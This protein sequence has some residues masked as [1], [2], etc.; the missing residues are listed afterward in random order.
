[1]TVLL[2]TTR[3]QPGRRCAISRWS[4]AQI[5]R[6]AFPMHLSVRSAAARRDQHC[7][8]PSLRYSSSAAQLLC[9]CDLSVSYAVL[10]NHSN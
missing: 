4:L 1:M 9:D 8:R 10:T 5:T 3:Q 2:T 6:D 7:A